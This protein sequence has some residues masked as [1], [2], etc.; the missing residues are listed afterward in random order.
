MFTLE[1]MQTV[2]DKL[3]KAW[4]LSTGEEFQFPYTKEHYSFLPDVEMVI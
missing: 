2:N 4:V 1:M 3:S